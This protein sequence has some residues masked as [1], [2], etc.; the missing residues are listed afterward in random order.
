MSGPNETV[1]ATTPMALRVGHHNF[2]HIA[3]VH[4]A[5]MKVSPQKQGKTIGCRQHMKSAL[6]A[7]A[8]G[9]NPPFKTGR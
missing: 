4:G 5:Y 7:L 2:E 6:P 9:T 3:A 8:A 1:A